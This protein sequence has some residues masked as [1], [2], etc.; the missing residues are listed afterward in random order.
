MADFVKIHANLECVS[1]HLER[2][3]NDSYL[4]LLNAFCSAFAASRVR[5]KSNLGPR[6][7]LCLFPFF[8]LTNH[9]GS[10]VQSFGKVSKVLHDSC[11]SKDFISTILQ[12]GSNLGLLGLCSTSRAV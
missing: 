9:N 1:T 3:E 7:N 11:D 8:V 2:K 10:Q 4:N 5:W 6:A 12:G